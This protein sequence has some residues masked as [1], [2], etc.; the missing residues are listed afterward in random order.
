MAKVT[1]RQFLKRAV[2]GGTAIVGSI[3]APGVMRK[4]YAQKTKL[5]IL[6][7]RHWVPRAADVDQEIINEWAKK[8]NVEITIDM[9][10]ESRDLRSIGSAEYKA[11]AGHDILMFGPFDGTSFKK[12]L[13]PMNDVTSYIQKKYGKF[14]KFAT[15]LSYQDGAWITVPTSIFSHTYPMISR[16]DLFR[17]HA[18]INLLDL[19]PADVAKRDKKKVDAW[20]YDAFLDVAKRLHNA[21][22]P[23]GNPISKVSDANAWLCALFLSFGSLPID[24]DRRVTIESEETLQ[25][26]EFMKELVHYMPKDIYGWD[27]MSNNRLLISG[28]GSCI[29]NPPSAWAVCMKTRPDIAEQLWHHDNPGGPK[30]RYRG[31]IFQNFGVWKWCKEKEAAKELIT[32][33]LEKPQQWKML[34]AA[35]GYDI[36]QLKIMGS[37]PVWEE[38][39]PPKGTIYNYIPRGDEQL[40]VGG[41]PAPPEIAAEIYNR[42]IVPEM[43]AKATTGKMSPKEA[44]KWAAMELETIG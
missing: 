27:N 44:M 26:I 8:N 19:F 7:Q 3:M 18:G 16:I 14:N 4:A 13:E 21:G 15:Y 1:R 24:K 10:F 40:I 32:Y 5:S 36:P 31:A 2:A 23:F 33:L 30:G 20:T 34:Q 12:N 35:K 29:Q 11:G 17:E 6:M 42:F 25:A 38:E 22:Y 43:V 39:G 41:W 9:I 28:K 37:H